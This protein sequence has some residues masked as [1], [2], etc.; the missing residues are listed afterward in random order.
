[1]SFMKSTIAIAK[2]AAV[3]TALTAVTLSSAQAADITLTWCELV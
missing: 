3:A 2:K 1:M